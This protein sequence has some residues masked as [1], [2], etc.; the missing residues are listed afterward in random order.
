MSAKLIE[1]RCPA[2]RDGAELNPSGARSA[3]MR[4]APDGLNTAFRFRIAE[5]MEWR[6]GWNAHEVHPG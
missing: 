5:R 4:L 1:R 2:R 6:L 3:R